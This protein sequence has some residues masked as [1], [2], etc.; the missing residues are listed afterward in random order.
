VKLD[1]PKL[2]QLVL[3]HSVERVHA[4]PIEQ[5]IYD[6]V[7]PSHCAVVFR[8]FMEWDVFTENEQNTA[9]MLQ[10]YIDYVTVAVQDEERINNDLETSCWMIR[11]TALI[12]WVQILFPIK[13]V[14]K[15]DRPRDEALKSRSAPKSSSNSKDMLHEKDSTEEIENDS[16]R[17]SIDDDGLNLQCWFV[18]KLTDLAGFCFD[19]IMANLIEK[20]SRIPFSFIF[21]ETEF[22]EQGSSTMDMI[23]AAMHGIW[24]LWDDLRLF[25]VYRLQICHQVLQ[26]TLVQLVN[27]L[28]IYPEYCTVAG[29][30]R[31]KVIKSMVADWCQS[32]QIHHDLRFKM[33]VTSLEE[34]SNLLL[35]C[36]VVENGKELLALCPTLSAAQINQIL[37]NYNSEATNEPLSAEILT[38][39]ME[40]AAWEDP[41]R[42]KR[43]SIQ[44]VGFSQQQMMGLDV[45]EYP[46]P[47]LSL[48]DVPVPPEIA[49]IPQLSF[50]SDRDQLKNIII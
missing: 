16:D 13:F 48:S 7:I 24:F 5:R 40:I 50:L 37:N 20:L 30:F 38:P 14:L 45:K 32:N 19:N 22:G 35:T 39:I 21:D 15:E 6:H 28:L 42:T 36:A 23:F 33:I 10:R 4:L 47:K 18:Q 1:Y 49:E 11:M 2:I 9:L 17:T 34:V 25:D 31:V 12:Y 43:L 46:L 44:D 41:S 8:C 26:Y 29:G 3:T 27:Q